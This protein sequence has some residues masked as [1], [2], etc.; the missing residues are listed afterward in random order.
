MPLDGDTPARNGYPNPRSHIDFFP[1]LPLPPS[2]SLTLSLTLFHICPSLSCYLSAVAAS[3]SLSFPRRCPSRHCHLPCL[4]PSLTSPSRTV[5]GRSGRS[6]A[7]VGG[8]GPPRL[9]RV[10]AVPSAPQ[11]GDSGGQ[12][13]MLLPGRTVTRRLPPRRRRRYSLSLSLSSAAGEGRRG[14]MGGESDVHRLLP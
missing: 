14:K 11:R 9:D 13:P 12:A 2:V 3:L 5:T 10:G 4:A 7:V 8:S 1:L 6:G